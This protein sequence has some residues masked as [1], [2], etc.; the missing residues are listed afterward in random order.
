MFAALP[1]VA[2]LGT[3]GYALFSSAPNTQYAAAPIVNAYRNA[4]SAMPP[5]PIAE[6][7]PFTMHPGTQ[8]ADGEPTSHARLC[9]IQSTQCFT[10]SAN[11]E[12]SKLQFF[13]GLDPKAERLPVTSGG[14]LIFF[15]G[16]FSGG[17]SGTSD[18]LTLLQYGPDGAIT[19]LLPEV[20]LSNQSE[21]RF[22]NL[23]QVSK[24][25]ILVTADFNWAEG[26]THFADHFY[27]LSAYVF[28]TKTNRYARQLKYITSKNYP[29]I[30]QADTIK[31]LQPERDT[32]TQKLTSQLTTNN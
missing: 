3:A 10:L 25:P 13:F 9:L 19:D 15:S 7:P 27:T 29:G 6:F 20:R 18:N 14:S 24:M 22:W 12:E 4:P 21:R 32:I 31:V 16:T 17:G 8:D 2:A 28:D 11:K 5:T 23:P 26:E 30:D 1:V